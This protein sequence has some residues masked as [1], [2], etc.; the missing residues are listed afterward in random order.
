MRESCPGR[1][2]PPSNDAQARGPD[3]QT[4]PQLRNEKSQYATPTFASQPLHESGLNTREGLL[5]AGS[6]SLS[7]DKQI[8]GNCSHPRVINPYGPAPHQA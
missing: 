4:A 7:G 3:P 5:S 6:Q 2:K 1:S 8:R